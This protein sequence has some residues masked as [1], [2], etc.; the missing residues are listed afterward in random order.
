[1]GQCNGCDDPTPIINEES[2][3]CCELTPANCV[4][5]S[6][7]QDFFKIAKG[8]TLTYVINKIAKVVKAIQLRVDALEGIYDYKLDE[9]ILNQ[10]STNVPSAVF[11]KTG[12]GGS[13]VFA[14]TGAGKYTLTNPGVFTAGKT[15]IN[16]KE[17]NIDWGS[18]VKAYW[19]DVD[20]IAI[21]SGSSTDYVDDDVIT[22]MPIEIK[23]YD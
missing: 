19:V 20:T 10:A 11:V 6:E 1:M 4:V 16:I 2:I 17:F 23:V 9:F 3:E 14:R 13:P 5:T 7:H 8:K 21:E 12:L 22:N 15:F 18:K